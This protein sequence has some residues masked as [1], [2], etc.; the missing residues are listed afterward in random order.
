M[1]LARA[2][3]DRTTPNPWGAA[4]LYRERPEDALQVMA[5][6]D[7]AFGPGRY[8]KTSER[9]REGNHHLPAL[10]F[11]VR[12]GETLIGTVRQWP[13]L[14]GDRDGLFLGPIAVAWAHR[15][16]GFGAALI[17][18][19]V[20]AAEAEDRA[21]ILLVGDMPV[22]GPHGFVVAP[23][24]RIKMPAPVHPGRLLVRPIAPGVLEAL[25]GPAR[26]PAR[27]AHG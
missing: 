16:R 22:F 27:A 23:S 14:I 6:A 12:E 20:A 17:A 3:L 11:C 8:A 21:F 4:R 5:L 10:S 13:I 7:Q 25:E 26:I 19:C 1:T 9:L 18:R 24:G 2:P 15:S